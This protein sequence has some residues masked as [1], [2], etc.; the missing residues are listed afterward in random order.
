MWLLKVEDVLRMTP[1]LLPHQVLKSQRLLV[2]WSPKMFAIF[3]SHQWLGFKHPDPNGEQLQ[4]LQGILSNLIARKLKLG[5]DCTSQ[6]MKGV[7]SEK[8]FNW[9]ASA[10][11]WL[12]Y[13]SVPQK[14]DGY[15]RGHGL[16]EEQSLYVYSIPGYVQ[17]CNMF[18]ALTPQSTH[19][20]KGTECNFYSWL[21][22]ANARDGHPRQDIL[23]LI[24]A[25][26]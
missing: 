20:D 24:S 17:R 5:E 11:I 19:C 22:M 16:A 10:Y 3:V 6:F 13:F 18:V 1:R 21:G 12:D 7:L 8:E 9:I 26:P 15:L 2:K 14:L 25:G 4:V 23:P